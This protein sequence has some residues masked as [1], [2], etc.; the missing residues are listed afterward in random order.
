MDVFNQPN[1]KPTK[2]FWQRPEGLTGKIVLGALLVAGAWFWNIIAAFLLTLV[3][4]TTKLII[5][6]VVLFALIY[7]LL[8]PKFR[9]LAWYFYT[10]TMKKLT[11]AF[12]EMNPIAIIK[13]YI[14]TLEKKREEMS[15]QINKMKGQIG[16]L[17]R[18]IFK[19]SEE[20][21]KQKELAKAA[22]SRGNN[23]Q[24]TLSAREVGRLD[25]SNSRLK[26]IKMRMEKMYTY[27]NKIYEASDYLIRDMKSEMS[28]QEREYNT[29]KAAYSVMRSASSIMKGDPDKRQI[30]EQALEFV[31]DDMGH[32]VGEIDRFME[33]SASI[34]NTIDL[35]NDVFQ[36][37]GLKMLEEMDKQ[38]FSFLLQPTVMPTI[39]DDGMKV[40]VPVKKSDNN[41][42]S[43]FD[44]IL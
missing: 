23:M 34:M 40:L 26:P 33:M 2:S 4:S 44:G 19:N 17:D 18:Q 9:N 35:E 32:K 20:I 24:V 36:E 25:G 27:M 38:D 28:T 37:K 6:G 8:D 31:Q 5:A 22:Q 7:V 1:N 29:I 13:V 12:V 42:N 11:S 21:D 39:T 10:V 15:E 14:Q 41:T 16:I 43:K 30:F 3:V